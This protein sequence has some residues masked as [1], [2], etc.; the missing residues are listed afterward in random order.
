MGE[1]FC[2]CRDFEIALPRTKI[3]ECFKKVSSNNYSLEY[4]EF[5]DAITTLGREFAIAKIKENKERLKELM[6][7]V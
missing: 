1:F 2:F 3:T 4:G 6:K 5:K 7:V